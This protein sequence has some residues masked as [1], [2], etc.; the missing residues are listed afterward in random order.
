M[1]QKGVNRLA[2]SRFSSNTVD[3]KDVAFSLVAFESIN[4]CRIEFRMSTADRGGR[5]DVQLTVLAHPLGEVIGEVPP[6]ASVSQSFWGMRLTSLDAAVFQLL[7]ALDFKL[8][9]Q[10]FDRG[11]KP[12]T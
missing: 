6:L 8:A 1:H 7:Y 2:S 12:E 3:S 9:E 4:S 10:E 11:G 5:A